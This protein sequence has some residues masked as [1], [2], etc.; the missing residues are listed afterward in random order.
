MITC[1]LR[2]KSQWLLL[3]FTVHDSWHNLLWFSAPLR[4]LRP[5]LFAF[6][7]SVFSTSRQ[8]WWK[9]VPLYTKHRPYDPYMANYTPHITHSF[10]PLG[11]FGCFL[12]IPKQFDIK[13]VPLI[14]TYPPA[15]WCW[16][17]WSNVE[18]SHSSWSNGE[19]FFP[20]E[21][22][23]DHHHQK[24]ICSNNTPSHFP[25]LPITLWRLRLVAGGM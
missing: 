4:I 9:I 19:L 10:R 21:N 7:L 20:F 3:Q 25:P 5:P 16:L 22:F 15:T 18:M 6:E 24:S 12:D 14:S 11:P 2:K 17:L 1:S 23:F 8:K 13:T